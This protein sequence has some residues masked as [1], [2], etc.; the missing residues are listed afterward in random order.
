[1]SPARAHAAAGH[2]EQQALRLL[3]LAA[4]GVVPA[5]FVLPEVFATAARAQLG[6]GLPGLEERPEPRRGCLRVQ[7]V[8]RGLQGDATVTPPLAAKPAGAPGSCSQAWNQNGVPAG[9][10]AGQVQLSAA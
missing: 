10:T 8:G 6:A 1:M 5:F 7:R 4:E 3:G 2:A 9:I